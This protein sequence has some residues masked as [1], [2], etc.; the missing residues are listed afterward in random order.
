MPRAR[1]LF[2][3]EIQRAGRPYRIAWPADAAAGHAVCPFHAPTDVDVALCSF[4]RWPG[5]HIV[6]AAGPAAI[7]VL[8]DVQIDA[9][10]VREAR[11][12]IGPRAGQH[13]IWCA[14][15]I[16]KGVEVVDA[17]NERGQRV[18]R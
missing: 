18:Q 7:V 10:P 9:V 14:E 5:P 4:P 11:A 17:H 2:G 8:E 6:P 13:A 1:L 15:P 16:A 3:G 12:L